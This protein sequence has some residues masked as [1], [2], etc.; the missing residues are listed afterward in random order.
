VSYTILDACELREKCLQTPF[1][2]SHLIDKAELRTASDHEVRA[3]LGQDI[4]ELG[5]E[6]RFVKVAEDEC[7]LRCWIADY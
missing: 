1:W 5:N 2:L 7:A 4:A 6:S 3:A